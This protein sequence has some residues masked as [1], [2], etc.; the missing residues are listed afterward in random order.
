MS[1][2]PLIDS[3][4]R[5]YALARVVFLKIL[6]LLRSLFSQYL[7]T[8]SLLTNL[9][10]SPDFTLMLNPSPPPPTPSSRE[11]VTRFF[12]SGFDHESSSPKPLKITLGSFRFFSKILGD[13]CKSRC[14]TGINDTGGK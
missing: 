5:I 4:L 12:A 11:S 7:L 3:C 1:L 6:G 2:S 10:S 8:V 9:Y 14:T 13:I